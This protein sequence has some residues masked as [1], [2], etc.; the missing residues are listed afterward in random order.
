[1]AQARRIKPKPTVRKAKT[2]SRLAALPWG[3]IAVILISGLVLALLVLGTQRNDVPVGQGLKSLINN[4]TTAQQTSDRVSAANGQ[5]GE[6]TPAV[7]SSD[8]AKVANFDYYQVLPDID[9][10]MP[11]DLPAGAVAARR[12]DGYQYYVQIASFRQFADAEALRAKLALQGVV[13][14][15]QASEVAG[16]GLYYRVR[17]GPF[18]N[19]RV[20][21]SATTQVKNLAHDPFVY[22]VALD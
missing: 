6:P 3:L 12:E 17:M 14:L 19:S 4:G 5:E 13:A 1:M 15:T 11:Q 22:R 16:Q 7:N 9:Q 8:S 18:E 21:K 20:A 10:V 2:S